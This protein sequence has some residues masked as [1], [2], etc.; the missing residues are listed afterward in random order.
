IRSIAVLPLANLSGDP[1]QEYFADGM[2]DEIIATLGQ[3]GE[4]DVISR[5]SS[6]QFKGSGKPLPEIARALHVDGV[7][8]GS[9]LVLPGSSPSDPKRVRI[10]ARLIEAGVDRQLWNRT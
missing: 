10:N 8:E 6:M 9:V 3:L 7:L 4:L 5:T 2:T 1:S